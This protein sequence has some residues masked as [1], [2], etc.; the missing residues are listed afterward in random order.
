MP[1]PPFYSA[2][3]RSMLAGEATE[4]ALVA[5]LSQTLGRN[6]RWIRP[7]ARRYLKRFGTDLRPRRK[8]V[9][10]FLRGDEHLSDALYR[11]RSEVHIARWIGDPALMQPAP[12]AAQWKVPAI[13]SVGTLATWLG[14][15]P[16]ELEWF[17]DRKRLCARKT[18]QV[19]GPLAH[20]HYR[21][22][23]KDSGDVRL[24]EAPKRRLKQIQQKIL[25][26]ILEKIPAHPAA[27]GF[28][29]S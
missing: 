20:Y 12:A 29:K 17:A 10:R 26:D 7:L 4:S 3:A 8:D 2:L 9:V 24:I 23:T 27:H 21:I 15:T 13:E 19:E 28:V 18:P 6:W 22:L 11:F 14:V 1:G 25:F 16:S 5:R